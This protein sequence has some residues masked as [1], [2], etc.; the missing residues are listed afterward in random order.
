MN[1]ELY[2]YPENEQIK[3]TGKYVIAGFLS[4]T[5]L[6]M[7]VF[8]LG[9][10]LVRSHN[11]QSSASITQKY[12]NNGIYQYLSDDALAQS[13]EELKVLGKQFQMVSGAEAVALINKKGQRVWASKNSSILNFSPVK[14]S[15]FSA[16][17]L[18]F[19]QAKQAQTLEHKT[20]GA[21]TWTNIL[22]NDYPLFTQQVVIVSKTNKVIGVARVA[23]D[24]SRFLRNALI[25]AFGLFS[26]VWIVCLLVFFVLLQRLR[27][28]L[29]VVDRQEKSLDE[30]AK[31]LSELSES[32]KTM[33]ANM[34]TASARAVE[35]NE[36]FLRRVGADLHDG[37]AQMIG[38]A[39]LRL[40]KIAEMEIAK[41]LGYEFHGIREAL[42]ESLDEIRGI[43]SGL[44]LPELEGMT[45][46]EC[47][48]KV[49][50]I[51]GTKS[52]AEV[53]QRFVNIPDDVPLP[54][55]ICAYRFVQ[56]GL[57]NAEQH[58]SAEKCRL[59][60]RYSNDR[61]EVSL[62]DN[63]VGFRVSTLKSDSI[64]LGLIGLKDRIE[65]IG[66]KFQINSELGNGTA[67]KF[68]V[69]ILET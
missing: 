39:N 8:F 18:D 26:F 19:F 4:I 63:G 10:Y 11:L 42:E 43:S 52:K 48:R 68:S 1:S 16:I 66:G 40:N 58:G 17:S 5:L 20:T 36:Q 54:I 65:S 60:V 34:Q 6:S 29:K 53:I 24:V 46:E 12:L 33:G 7:F 62:K 50:N 55:K 15:V 14:S 22:N 28:V 31:N 57:N 30:N 9:Y 61:L 13:E 59:D 35:L 56:E 45:L 23:I 49:V 37:P 25:I 2:E 38:Y 44:V 21:Q 67:I 41:Q 64:H 27:K 47:M 51:H 69:A 32:N 3:L